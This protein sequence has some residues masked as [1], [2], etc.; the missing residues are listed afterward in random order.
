MA[1]VEA[2]LA[3]AE[4]LHSAEEKVRVAE[5]Q[6]ATAVARVV[7]DYKELKDFED[8]AIAAGVDTYIFGFTDCWDMI[9]QAYPELDMSNILVLREV[10]GKG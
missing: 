5:E 3:Q 7:H 1:K 10:E 9:A 8:D 4:G 6:A 2:R